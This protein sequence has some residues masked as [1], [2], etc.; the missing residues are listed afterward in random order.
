MIMKIEESVKII[1]LKEYGT[2][3]EFANSINLPYSTVYQM[4]K[5]GFNNSVVDN[6]LAVCNALN[7]SA[8]SLAEGHIKL[9][10][11]PEFKEPTN[12]DELEETLKNI[13]DSANIDRII[14]GSE[15]NLLKNNIEAVILLIRNE[16]KLKP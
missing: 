14:S 2:L 1:I 4:F 16:R 10:D 15:C 8:D 3:K 9:K 11:K 7:L 6:V 5:R 13:L 12:L